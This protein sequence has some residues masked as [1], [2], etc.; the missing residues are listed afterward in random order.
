MN[1]EQIERLKSGIRQNTTELVASQILR[2]V[3]PAIENTKNALWGPI[4]TVTIERLQFVH[5]SGPKTV[6][7]G[8]RSCPETVE[9]LAP[10]KIDAVKSRIVATKSG[11][12][13]VMPHNFILYSGAYWNVL[14]ANNGCALVEPSDLA[15]TDKAT[16]LRTWNLCQKY[17]AF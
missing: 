4:T 17:D 16:P 8:A 10:I 14:E 5:A 11:M 1:S 12:L 7:G 13:H 2:D 15:V 9:L 3:I 6:C